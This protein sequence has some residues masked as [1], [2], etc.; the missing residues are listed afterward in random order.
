[1]STQAVDPVVSRAK[2]EREI[3]QFRELEGTYRKRGWLLLQA[4]FPTAEIGFITVKMNPPML[5]VTARFDFTNYDVWPISVQFIDPRT[6]QV[7]PK[8]LMPT[9]MPRKLPDGSIGHA[10]QGF[11]GTPAFL[12]MP[13]VREYHDNPAHS[14]DSW[15]LHRGSGEG[16]LAFLCQQVSKF[17]TDPVVGFEIVQMGFKVEEPT[18]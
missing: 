16:K 14:G 1:M 9:P 15:L 5:L 17:A 11:P 12:C 4:N 7:L 2:F 8:E 13:G 6:G 10:V 18:E 3:A